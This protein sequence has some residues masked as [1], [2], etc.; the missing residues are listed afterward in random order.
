M[1]GTSPSRSTVP[2]GMPPRRIAVAELMAGHQDVVLVHNDQDYHLRITKTGK[3]I[4]T[5]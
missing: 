1:T 4:L 5:K 2:P 3:L